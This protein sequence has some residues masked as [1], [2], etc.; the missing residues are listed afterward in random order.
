M[1]H[2]PTFVD[3]IKAW[4]K[5]VW[6]KS[7]YCIAPSFQFQAM[8]AH[9]WHRASVVT[10]QQQ[11]LNPGLSRLCCAAGRRSEQL[12]S[13]RSPQSE[14]SDYFPTNLLFVWGRMSSFCSSVTLLGSSLGFSMLEYSSPL[15]YSLRIFCGDSVKKAVLL[16]KY[17]N[18][19]Y[20]RHTWK[21]YLTDNH[22]EVP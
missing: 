7:L 15:T 14:A 3:L 18:S 5:K 10:R 11:E 13:N 22:F 2:A 4:L 19:M 17:F 8:G 20:Q 16:M 9:L 21:S 6:L 1:A 12:R